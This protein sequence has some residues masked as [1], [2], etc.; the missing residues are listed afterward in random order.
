MVAI[1][2]TDFFLLK[3]DSS[4]QNFNVLN[5]IV[6]AAGFTLYRVFMKIDTPLGNTLPVMLITVLLCLAA[7]KIIGGAKNV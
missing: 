7:N 4:E 2:I 6:W 5:I 1:L 3:K